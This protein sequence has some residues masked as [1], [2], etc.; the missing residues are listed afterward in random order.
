MKTWQSCS[1]CLVSTKTLNSSS[2]WLHG[3]SGCK[4]LGFMQICSSFHKKYL[5]NFAFTS[6]NVWNEIL[7]NEINK[8]FSWKFS[9]E[10]FY[11]Y[12]W[13]ATFDHTLYNLAIPVFFQKSLHKKWTF[14]LR[15]SSVNVTKS[16]G[17]CGFVHIYWRNL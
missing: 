15:I 16:S 5:L 10:C 4:V 12:L 3:V 14:L 7:L 17:N 8:I 1:Y 11:K 6:M 2:F 9:W 13:T